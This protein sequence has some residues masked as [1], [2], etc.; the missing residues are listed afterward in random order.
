MGR[1][2][3]SCSLP[4]EKKYGVRRLLE[5]SVA[6]FLTGFALGVWRQLPVVSDPELRPSQ[7]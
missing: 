7:A 1:Q 6:S 4:G 5:E 3:L 2:S